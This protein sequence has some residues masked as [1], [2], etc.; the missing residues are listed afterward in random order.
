MILYYLE[1]KDSVKFFNYGNDF[2]IEIFNEKML[3]KFLT[4]CE[5]HNCLLINLLTGDKKKNEKIVFIKIK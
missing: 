4:K 1:F 5:K 2:V 3:E